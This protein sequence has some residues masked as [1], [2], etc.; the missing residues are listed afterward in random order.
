MLKLRK[1]R[2]IFWFLVASVC[3]F[4]L[5]VLFLTGYIKYFLEPSNIIL[6]FTVILSG[7]N[8]ITL[9]WVL[10]GWSNPKSEKEINAPS[11]YF[12]PNLSFS[13][14]VPARNEAG[15]IKDTLS[16]IEKIDYPKSLFETVVLC[17]VDD[18]KT[19][20]AVKDYIHSNPNTMTR[21]I[22]FD[23][24]ETN[25][26][27]AL[28]IG[29]TAAKGNVIG[30]F[31]AEDEP[32]KE[33]LNIVNTIMIKESKDVVQSGVQLMD[34]NSHWFSLF[35]VLEYFFWFK[36]GLHFFNKVGNVAPLGGNTIFVKKPFLDKV[37][38]WDENCLTED[39]DMGIRL[40]LVNAKTRITYDDR[41]L[42]K[43]ETPSTVKS[44][45]K[46]RTRWMQGFIQIFFKSDWVGLPEFRQKF[47][48]VYILLSPL[49]QTLLIL[50][51]P[52]GV[53]ISQKFV[54]PL[55]ISLLSY[56]PFYLMAIQLTIY[57]IGFYKFTKAHKKEFSI[58][59]IIK[60]IFFYYP[61]QILLAYASVRALIRFI[62]GIKGWEKTKH[63]N[64][65]RAYETN[66]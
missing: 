55:Y 23:S 19:I 29:L 63:I 51:I 35:N 61:Y 11:E 65:H 1:N 4:I 22:V 42:T 49:I 27:V 45:V 36:S 59:V 39:A 64:A 48:C 10:Y 13:L 26:P 41:Y 52:L 47:L 30:I 56:M 7:Q 40:R 31:D 17:K 57:L 20:D 58:F 15:V 43:E 28:N 9:T 37:G 5:G 33:I 25:K 8:L 16:T 21:L 66:Y 3:S 14:L 50:Y 32:S 53:Y 62:F 38:G 44:F 60:M 46:Q 6:L 24:Y 54:L 18:I 2:L 34:H 12:S